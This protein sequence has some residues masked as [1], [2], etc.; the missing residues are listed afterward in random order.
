M[1][2]SK[3]RIFIFDF[4]KFLKKKINTRSAINNKVVRVCLNCSRELKSAASSR[5][6]SE[7]EIKP[8]SIKEFIKEEPI[9]QL[10]AIQYYFV[11]SPS[12]S[13]LFF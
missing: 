8:E 4:F 1:F 2:F 9:F 6:Q 7:I 5:T 13:N 3:V 10:E 12:N 11:H